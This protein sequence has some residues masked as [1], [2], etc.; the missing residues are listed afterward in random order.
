MRR[1]ARPVH[2]TISRNR[3][4]FSGQT[5]LG[6]AVT[7]RV[8]FSRPLRAPGSRAVHYRVAVDLSDG[9]IGKG[10]WVPGRPVDLI[11]RRP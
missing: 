11:A 2:G 6:A 4:D 10:Y 5:H 7:G 3:P 1:I 9:R 8:R